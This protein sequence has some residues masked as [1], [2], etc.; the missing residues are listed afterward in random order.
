MLPI[1][2]HSS[3]A[4]PIMN[5]INML[6]LSFLDDTIPNV[7]SNINNRKLEIECTRSPFWAKKP[8]R[9]LV[10]QHGDIVI[11]RCGFDVDL[12]TQVEANS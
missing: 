2:L 6:A 3:T 10:G 9:R 11:H 1:P 12:D 4:R 5:V 8:G 7:V